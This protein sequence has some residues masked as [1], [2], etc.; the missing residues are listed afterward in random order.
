MLWRLEDLVRHCQEVHACIN[1]KYVPSRPLWGFSRFK[2][3][4]LVWRG[5][6]DAFTWPEG[7]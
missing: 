2:A 1:G 7:Q 5:K 3:A 6:A 4:W